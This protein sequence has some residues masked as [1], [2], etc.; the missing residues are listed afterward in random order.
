MAAQA[1]GKSKPNIIIILADDL[2]YG[3]LG[4]YGGDVPV[5]A[6]E[7]MAAEGMRFTDFHSNGAVCSPTRAALLTGRYQ[8]R[9]GIEIPLN[10][11][12]AGLGDV[13][14][15]DEVTLAKYLKQAGY[16][17]GILGKWHLGT[18]NPL[19]YGFD[20]FKGGI[21][22][23][24]DYFSKITRDGNYDWWENDKL[25]KESDYNTHLIT[26]HAVKFLEEHKGK[27]FF[28]Y[29]A[30]NAI[31]FPWQRL[32]DSVY[33]KENFKY[34]SANTAFNK[35]GPHPPPMVREVVQE[36][37]KE[38]DKSVGTI[39]DALRDLH[40][41][42]NTLV[43]FC[44]DN[45]G[46]VQYSGG[47]DN[48]SSNKPFR[49]EKGRVY[50]GGHRVPAIVRWPGR[51][52]EGVI[53]DEAIMTMDLVPTLLELA[54]FEKNDSRLVNPLDGQSI[55]PVLFSHQPMKKRKLFW[56]HRNAFAVRWGY[57]KLVVSDNGIPEL[58]N[59][60]IDVAEKNNIAASNAKITSE[61]MADLERWKRDVYS[62]N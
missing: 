47:Y 7:K 22:G 29:V 15:K 17:T 34:G 58:Y 14:A 57:W 30:Q 13:K 24:G 18:S 46:I 19:N 48:I 3:D 44:S 8:Q 43:L 21:H 1:Q 37:I 32:G 61:L 6:L 52:Q 9:M 51:I 16:Y 49:G 62:K 28:L 36:M 60:K 2:G 11:R 56:A 45:G 31:H 33:R 20:E 5:P 35:L 27:P 42:D 41:D 23:S 53:C 59:L 10:P 38:L 4:L 50:E 40:L 12:D 25:V 54:G 26:K 55:S 39:L